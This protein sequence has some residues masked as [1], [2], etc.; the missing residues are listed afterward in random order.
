TFS[1]APTAAYPD[2]NSRVRTFDPSLP[3]S[4]TYPC[5]AMSLE[6]PWAA[7]SSGPHSPTGP[8]PFER[9]SALMS[10]SISARQLGGAGGGARQPPATPA[11]S[12]APTTNGMRVLPPGPLQPGLRELRTIDALAPDQGAPDRSRGHEPVNLDP[13]VRARD[14]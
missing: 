3:M 5:T 13:T 8:I 4:P 11:P 10:F 14:R 1:P 7:T 9:R 12:P 6:C 2:R